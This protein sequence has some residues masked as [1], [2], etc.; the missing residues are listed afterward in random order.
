MTS[1]P[2]RFAAAI[3]IPLAAVLIAP[4]I[5]RTQTPP[6]GDNLIL[7][8]L[9]GA[10]TE[11]IF[12]GLDLDILRSTLTEKA[13]LEEQP[14][15]KRFNAPSPEERRRKMMP[16]FWDT[17]V[18][19]HGSIAGNPR[20]QSSVTLTNQH[21]F[22]YPGYAEILLGEAH[23]E[24]IKSNDRVQNPFE[25]L[26]ERLRTHLQL[27]P[28]RVAT[29]GSWEVFNEIAEHTPG[30][31]TIN[32]GYEAFEHPAA[33][34]QALSRLQFETP[35]P[36]NSV[37]HDAYTFGLAMAHLESSRPRV[38][39]LALGETDDWAHGGRYDCV[40]ETYARTDAYLEQLWT[41]LQ[42]DEGYRGRTHL[43]ITTDHGRGKTASDWR[44]HGAKV[45]GAQNV[46]MAFV[47]PK[48][49][50]R[51][52]WRDHAPIHTSQAAATMAAW[53]GLDWIALRP[54]AG[55]PIR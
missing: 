25:T 26:L 38:L 23:D 33:A 21:R 7:I 52:E 18:T 15:F 8:T 2:R 45:E 14:V 42:A 24:V 6:A 16:F 44:N 37:R 40:L 5:V 1:L 9:D 51:G 29:F 32:A 50:R 4:G 48:L 47:S 11:E 46:W 30:S 34:V 10:R 22:S 19:E 31:L 54:R 20:L 27:P 3:V 12:G 39:Y 49:A 53:M 35:T 13:V 41:W 17:L 36:W 43:L 28:S 55:A